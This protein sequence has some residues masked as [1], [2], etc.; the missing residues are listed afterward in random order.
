M[1]KI[2]IGSGAGYGGDRLEPALELMEKGKLDYIG[3]EC[4]AERTIA[5][6]QEQKRIDPDKGYNHLLNYR[7]EK[8]IP[9]AYK[10]KIKVITNMGAA[11]PEKAAK[12]IA[13]LAKQA[14]AKGMKIAAV[15]GDDVLEQIKGQDDLLILET[16]QPLSSIKENIVSANAYLGALPIVEALQ[17]GADIIV[18]G[19]VADP[20]LFLAPLI[21]EFDWSLEDYVKLGKGTLI[22]HLLECAAQVCG[23]YF[24]DPGVKDVPELWNVGFPFVEVNESGDGFVS[25]IP[26]SGGVVNTATCTEQMLYEIHDPKKYFTPDC[27]A[28]FSKVEFQELGKD[29]VAFI[30]GTGNQATETYKVSVGYRN[31]F[32]GEGEISYGGVNCL[33]RAELAIEILQKRLVSKELSDLRF[34]M[35][36]VN[37]L[38]TITQSSVIAEPSE[39]RIRVAGKSINASEAR[40]IGLEVEALYTNGPAGGGGAT[41]KLSELISIASVLMPKKEVKTKIIYQTID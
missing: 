27:T 4:L 25:K 33:K 28:D 32:L 24:A 22:G 13:E 26:G 18:T 31:G 3:F 17:N 7:M 35:I 6:A 9:L 20:S 11:N 21:Y 38:N 10:N 1:K 29:K 36:G 2:R 8:V 19:R 16:G 37:S 39:I 5:I 23:G 15:F 40:K 30:G 41:Q 12:I 34:E 14:G